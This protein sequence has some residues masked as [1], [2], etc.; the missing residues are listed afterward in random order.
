VSFKET[1][2]KTD[3]RLKF[4][5]ELNTVTK[6]SVK[7]DIRFFAQRLLAFVI[8]ASLFWIFILSFEDIFQTLALNVFFSALFIGCFWETAFNTSPGDL[9]PETAPPRT[10]VLAHRLF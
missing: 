9:S 7:E 8:D 1:N 6:T 3:E 10:L 4:L 5:S 2:A